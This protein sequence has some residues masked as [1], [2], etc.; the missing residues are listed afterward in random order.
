MEWRKSSRLSGLVCRGDVGE[1]V[2]HAR[3]T[4]GR[5]R[6]IMKKKNLV[7]GRTKTR[8]RNPKRPDN[9]PDSLFPSCQLR[10]PPLTRTHKHPNLL[11]PLHPLRFPRR[12]PQPGL[13]E[14]LDQLSI[15]IDYL[16]LSFGSALTTWELEMSLGVYLGVSER[17]DIVRQDQEG[18]E[19]RCSSR[20][21]GG[22]EGG[23]GT[24]GRLGGGG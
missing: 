4:K 16:P 20:G 13:I 10:Q 21:L 3:R 7:S 11:P 12:H 14:N 22:K 5:A 9:Q 8:A 19:S 1:A 6:M 15:P 24:G 23:G 18:G 2:V 17:V